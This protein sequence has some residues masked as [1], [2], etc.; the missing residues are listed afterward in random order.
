LVKM[1]YQAPT[2]VMRVRLS[3]GT[4]VD[5]LAHY[6][7]R[8]GRDRIIRPYLQGLSKTPGRPAI[9]VSFMMPAF[10]RNHLYTFPDPARDPAVLQKQGLWTALNFFNDQP[11]N[12]YLNDGYAREALHARF[13]ASGGTPAYGDLIA[14]TSPA[15]DLVHASVYIADNVVFTRNGSDPMQPWVLMKIPDLVAKFGS[16]V[17]AQPVV[18]HRKQ[19]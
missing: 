8:G 7:G 3:P 11:D 5:T 2:F 15:G 13:E 9:S 10:A 18:Y 4:D 6:W 12:R 19:A 17:M 1:L 14:L 16:P